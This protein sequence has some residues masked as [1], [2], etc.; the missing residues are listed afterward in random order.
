MLNSAKRIFVMHL[1][2][3]NSDLVLQLGVG[4]LQN[5]IRLL[6]HIS[7][8]LL[9]LN[10]LLAFKSNPLDLLLKSFNF[11]AFL[12]G[13]LR[14]HLEVLLPLLELFA[15]IG[16]LPITICFSRLDLIEQLFL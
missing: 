2:L 7:F 6:N 15:L 1:L 4:L 16:N 14:D 5:F 13:S 8:L 11:L 9:F 12:P 3:Q 10:F